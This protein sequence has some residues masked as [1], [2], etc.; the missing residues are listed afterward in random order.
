MFVFYPKNGSA[1]IYYILSL[2]YFCKIECIARNISF[3][4]VQI[5]SQVVQKASQGS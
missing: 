2:D 4:G 3:L 1:W 5:F